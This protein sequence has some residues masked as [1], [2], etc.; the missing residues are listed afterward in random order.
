MVIEQRSGG[1]K[2]EADPEPDGLTANKKI[3]VAVPV[4]RKRARAKK[5]DN[6]DDK[7][8]EHGKEQNISA[9]TMHR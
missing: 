3:N 1:A 8:P 6:A 7:H 9:L 4:L 5:H 2:E